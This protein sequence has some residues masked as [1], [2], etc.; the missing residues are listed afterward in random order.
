MTSR[1]HVVSGRFWVIHNSDA[2]PG[3]VSRWNQEENWPDYLIITLISDDT[4][5]G[6]REGVKNAYRDKFSAILN[7][8]LGFPCGSVG[9]ESTCNAGDLGLVPGL[10]RSLG[11]GNGNSLQYSCLENSMD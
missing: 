11:E 3:R 6:L 8:I 9:K 5:H 2:L 7:S 1:F 4:H 10:G